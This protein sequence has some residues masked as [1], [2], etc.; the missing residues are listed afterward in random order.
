[1]AA[2]LDDSLSFDPFAGHD[3]RRAAG[4]HEGLRQPWPYTPD[5]V[6]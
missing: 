3:Q 6:A 2:E 5:T 4:Y 1:L